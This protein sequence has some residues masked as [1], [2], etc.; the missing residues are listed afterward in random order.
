MIP[1]FPDSHSLL[2]YVLDESL[3]EKLLKQLKKDFSLANIAIDISEAIA[4]DALITKLHEKIYRLI[5]ENFDEYLN[6]LYII[7]VPENIF[8]EIEVVDVVEVAEK[9]TFIVLKRELQKIWLKAKYS[10]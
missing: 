9:V 2:K 10:G 3:Y 4:P 8:K 7:D 6:L 5:L 1:F